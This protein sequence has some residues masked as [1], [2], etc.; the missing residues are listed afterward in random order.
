VDTLNAEKR[1]TIVTPYVDRWDGLQ[2]GLNGEFGENPSANPYECVN[3]Y[4]MFAD[5]L[6]IPGIPGNA[7]DFP[8]NFDPAHYV[9]IANEPD[10]APERGDCV[11]FDPDA[12]GGAGLIS[13]YGHVDLCIWAYRVQ[14]F[15]GLDQDYPT[16]SEVHKQPHSYA[17]VAGWLRPKILI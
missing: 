1:K 6:H 15:L 2:L 4:N 5:F 7:I 8:R 17:G 13:K 14:Y 11:C 3:V 9:W 16:G 10:N 12:L